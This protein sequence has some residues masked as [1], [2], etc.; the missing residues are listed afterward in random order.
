MRCNPVLPTDLIRK[1]VD[2]IWV[3][4]GTRAGSRCRDLRYASGGTGDCHP[5]PVRAGACEQSPLTVT[6]RTA[7]LRLPGVRAPG[8]V[9]RTA[10]PASLRR[11]A[12]LQRFRGCAQVVFGRQPGSVRITGEPQQQGRAPSGARADC[13]GHLA[14]PSRRVTSGPGDLTGP[15]SRDAGAAASGGDRGAIVEGRED[16]CASI[17]ADHRRSPYA[18]GANAR[19]DSEPR[20]VPR[21]GSDTTR[22]T[23]QTVASALEHAGT[24]PDFFGSAV[25][26]CGTPTSARRRHRRRAREDPPVLPGGQCSR[27]QKRNEPSQ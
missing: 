5:R 16:S 6:G 24:P 2:L 21:R 8:V 20:R 9:V 11:A 3:P 22:T 13:V 25:Y 15:S 4:F 17:G 7:S 18:N 26:R 19:N 10:A 23:R 14:R 12:R 1:K 27:D